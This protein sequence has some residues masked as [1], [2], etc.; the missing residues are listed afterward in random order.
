MPKPRHIRFRHKRARRALVSLKAYARVTGSDIPEDALVDFVTDAGH[1]ADRDG[2]D[3]PTLMRRAIA[4]WLSEQV[5]PDSISRPTVAI[6][7][8][9]VEITSR[10][11]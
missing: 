5:D 8:D 2:L 9:G 11:D 7:A 4:H 1:L 10:P 3:F 6:Y